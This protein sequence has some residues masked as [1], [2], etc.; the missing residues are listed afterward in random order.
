M[1]FEHDAVKEEAGRREAKNS[2]FCCSGVETGFS[3]G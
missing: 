2:G 1:L 3:G